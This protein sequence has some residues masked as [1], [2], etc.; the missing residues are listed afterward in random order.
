MYQIVK[1]TVVFSWDFNQV[2]N[3]TILNDIVL[4]N[5][6]IFND[7]DDLDICLTTNNQYGNEYYLLSNKHFNKYKLSRFNQRIDNL[8]SSI[9][10]LTLGF[11]FNQN[12]DNLPHG[13][14]DLTLG[15]N[16]N[17]RLDNLPSSIINLT[18]GQN[19]NQS[20]EN[21]PHSINKIIF[22]SYYDIEFN[23]EIK[24]IPLNLTLVDISEIPNRTH[25]K[26]LFEKFNIEIIE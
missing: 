3:D 25:L 10:D 17:Q 22:K 1:Q 14:R 15:S 20:I 4:C 19:F 8:P 9:T 21:L 26:K 23:Q 2:L 18:F 16:F 12:I 6:I 24:K 13:I 5:K 7:Y 11:Y